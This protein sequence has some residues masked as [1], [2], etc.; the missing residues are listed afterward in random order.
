MELAP[1]AQCM[2][3]VQGGAAKLQFQNDSYSVASL[4]D[5][6]NTMYFIQILRLNRDCPTC[7]VLSL[8]YSD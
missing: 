2:I 8:M 5:G 6:V 3:C 7:H 1:Q 4:E